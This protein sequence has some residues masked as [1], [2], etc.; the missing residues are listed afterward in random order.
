MT[1]IIGC[2]SGSSYTAYETLSTLRFINYCKVIKNKHVHN[3]PKKAKEEVL[4][5][6]LGA[7]Y[8]PQEKADPKKGLKRELPWI[9]SSPKITESTVETSVGK[10]RMISNNVEDKGMKNL[11]ILMHACPSSCD[12][13]LHFFDSLTYYRYK[14]VAF[15]FPGFGGSPGDRLASRSDKIHDKGGPAE[16]ALSLLSYLGYTK[17]IF[18]GYDWGAGVALGI[19]QKYPSKVNKIIALLP[20][21]SPSKNDDMK[22]I[23]CPVLVMWVKQ[24]QMHSWTRWKSLANLIPRKTIKIFD[25]K[26]YGRDVAGGAYAGITNKIGREISIFLGHPDPLKEV[27][28]LQKEILVEDKDTQGN[29]FQKKQLLVFQDQLNEVEVEDGL[30]KFSKFRE[31]LKDISPGT[32]KHK[33]Y[34]ISI[35]KK[36]F[37]EI[38]TLISDLQ[39]LSPSSI[40]RDPSIL[41]YEGVWDQL[42]LN[43]SE[44]W[45]SPYYA[46]GV[47]V[48]T[49]ERTSPRILSSNFLLYDPNGVDRCMIFDF[50][51]EEISKESG[52]VLLRC[53]SDPSKSLTYPLE[54]LLKLNHPQKFGVDALGRTW[55]EDGMRCDY[56]SYLLKAKLYGIGYYLSPIVS[57]LDFGS[58]TSTTTKL[59]IDALR[60][61][62][63][64][65]NLTSFAG[66][67]DKSRIGRTDCVGEL[68]FNGQAQCH[69]FSST[70]SSILLVFG[71]LLGIEVLYRG[72]TSYLGTEDVEA[73][74]NSNVEKHQWLEVVLRPSNK[75][76]VVDLW[77]ANTQNSIEYIGMSLEKALKT[78]VCPH[79]KLLLKNTPK[80]IEATDFN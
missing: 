18:G 58:S 33:E 72:G 70:F 3:T 60:I 57:N 26:K 61:M 47:R 30:T 79:A 13:L 9:S 41:V 8:K 20:S 67:V 54:E 46:K 80:A 32:D 56:E 78:F 6:L 11:V 55:L 27:T 53:I 73:C 42:P 24:D 23:S 38:R 44:M 37:K 4:K 34:C 29:L 69:G 17:A 74:V 62:F 12:E 28:V 2:I 43:L 49:N 71:R 76:V 48:L 35:L 36:Q 39:T 10:L 21:Y 7:N 59:Q 22:L 19:A 14:V 75:R 16:C 64:C 5:R 50:E 52:S 45:N 65:L 51:I 31:I 1:S 68:L 15:D 63:S 77:Y 40:F 66:G 25:I